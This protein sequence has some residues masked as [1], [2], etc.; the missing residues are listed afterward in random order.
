LVFALVEIA[1]SAY[2]LWGVSYFDRLP[3]LFTYMA[4][5]R[6]EF[7]SFLAVKLV[8]NLIVLL[9]P[10]LMFG[11]AFPLVAAIY[12]ERAA[13]SGGDIGLVYSANTV[14]GI[15]GSFVGGFLLLPAFGAQATITAAG[16]AGLAVAASI[17]L[18]LERRRQRTGVL[19]SSGLALAIG[20]VLYH[21]WDARLIN[22]APYIPKYANVETL[23]ESKSWGRL[24]YFKEGINVNVSVIGN[25]DPNSIYING[26][27]MAS[28]MITDVANQYLLGHLPML[29]HPN[30]RRSLV[31]GLGAGMTF[32]ALASHGTPTDCVEISP[33]VVEGA[34]L[35][36]DYN[37]SV[38][39]RPNANLIFDDG[40]NYLKTTRKK[41]D[42]I[43]EDPLDPFFAGSGYL[44]DL[45]HFENAKKA[46]NPG[47]VMCQYL[48]LYQVGQTEVRI[49][50]KTFRAV[51]PHVTAWFAYNDVLLIGSEEPLRIDWENLTTRISDPGISRD[52]REI[53]IDNAHDFLAN[54]LFDQTA[55]DE[56]GAGLPLNTDDYPIIEYMAPR[57]LARQ[58]ES[59]NVSYFL[60]KRAKSL[61]DIVDLGS[62]SPSEV[63]EFKALQGAYYQARGHLMEVHMRQFYGGGGIGGE[64]AAAERLVS[65][66][67]TASYYLAHIFYRG[68]MKSLAG[69]NFRQALGFLEKA[70]S[71]RP[72]YPPIMSSLGLALLRNGKK[73]ESLD[74]F[75]KSLRMDE[76][77][78]IPR[79]Y[80]ADELMDRSE[81]A[82]ARELIEG[83][84]EID[85]DNAKC[86]ASMKRIE[87]LGSRL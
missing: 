60:S 16:V 53:G 22:S 46:M 67:T 69:R 35:F 8:I 80:I 19:I 26:K 31:I 58:T 7:A 57:A 9:L 15:F 11:A 85:P 71:Y 5:G 6:E 3:V 24:L 10:T 18:T 66:R 59:R 2:C 54:Y 61:P 20:V 32:G 78:V 55:I 50:V 41:Y 43:T 40:R 28:T 75:E 87:S 23:L 12:A 38:L 44:Y 56:I 4:I 84:L 33:E 42:V 27:P 39:D 73:R 21:P 81:F 14:G 1:A 29:L 82:R 77:Q 86:I 79:I 83:C 17:A 13:S 25:P 34:R 74:L 63:E 52:L 37:R 76:K 70:H 48:P 36:G 30:P 49:I 68:G 47:G 65:P 72:D 45:E 64:I 62:L 51:F